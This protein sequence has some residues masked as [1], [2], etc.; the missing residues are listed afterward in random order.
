MT[1]GQLLAILLA[2]YGITFTLRDASITRR[3]R[4]WLFGVSDF[5]RDLVSCPFCL[6]FWCTALS[7]VLWGVHNPQA[8]LYGFAGAPVCWLLDLV[9]TYLERQVS[10]D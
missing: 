4:E 1:T 2:G 7:A 6:G 5:A 8:I 9:G 3:L 10:T